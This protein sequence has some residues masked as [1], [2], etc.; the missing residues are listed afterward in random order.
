MPTV[1]HMSQ[2]SLLAWKVFMALYVCRCLELVVTCESYYMCPSV[3]FEMY[4]SW[5][6]YSVV[7]NSLVISKYWSCCY[8]FFSVV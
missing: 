3:P 5:T 1:L 8:T 6:Y 7:T 4:H 2:A